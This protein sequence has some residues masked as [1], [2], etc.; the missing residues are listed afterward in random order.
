MVDALLASFHYWVVSLAR[1]TSPVNCVGIVVSYI[2]LN[3]RVEE[4]LTFV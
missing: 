4:N 1:L 2:K 3:S